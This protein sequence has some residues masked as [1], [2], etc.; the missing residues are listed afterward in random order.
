MNSFLCLFANC[1]IVQGRQRSTICDLQRN[2]FHLIPNSLSSLFS[3]TNYINLSNLEVEYDSSNIKTLNEYIEFLLSEELAFY[4]NTIDE[5]NRFPKLDLEWEYPA[6]ITNMI[7]DIDNESNFDLEIIIKSCE[8]VNCRHLQ[9]RYFKNVKISELSNLISF[10]NESNI[11]CVELLIQSHKELNNKSIISFLKKNKKIKTI[12]LCN[13]RKDIILFNQG[14]YGIGTILCTKQKL[15][16][17][18]HCGNFHF[19]Y[20]TINIETFCEAQ[21]Y[22][23]CLNRKISIDKNGNIKN[24]PSMINNFGQFSESNLKSAISNPEFTK[25][26]YINKDSISKCKECEF[27]YICS[28]CR[29]YL[30]DPENIYSAPLKCGYNPSTM[31]WDNWQEDTSKNKIFLNYENLRLI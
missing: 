3:K 24:C 27:R 22:N 17:E 12:I 2:R 11:I 20:F 26:W 1:I 8:I 10:V 4:A 18:L 28:D 31:L 21:K 13:C 6:L 9:L 23:T 29:V 5:C 19:N 14:G 30:D 25:Y 7:I 16:N 15:N